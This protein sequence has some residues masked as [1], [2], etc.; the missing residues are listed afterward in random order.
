MKKLNRNEMEVLSNVIVS[1][2]NERKVKEVEG[3]LEKDVDFKK[4]KKLSEEINEMNKKLSVLNKNYNEVCLKVRNKFDDINIW[5]DGNNNDLKINFNN[6]NNY[7]NVKI[8]N[9]LVLN[10]IG[11]DFNVD[12]LVNKIV[13]K[14][15]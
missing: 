9:D 3:K 12:E 2:I 4:L 10:S 15:S 7:N 1:K 14:Y 13:E 8:Y 11:N 5:R 6:N